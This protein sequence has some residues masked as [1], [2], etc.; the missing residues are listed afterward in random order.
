MQLALASSGEDGAGDDGSEDS[1]IN[2][3]LCHKCHQPGRLV[4][5][6][7]CFRSWHTALR[8]M[9]KDAMP[10]DSDPWLCPVCSGSTEHAGYVGLPRVPSQRGSKERARKRGRAEGTKPQVAAAKK[11]RRGSTTQSYR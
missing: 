1:G 7:K 2:D 5:C 8:C 4:C 10:V 9:P 3:T 6:S 11:A